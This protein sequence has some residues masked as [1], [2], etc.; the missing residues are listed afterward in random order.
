LSSKPQIKEK[1]REEGSGR[2]IN[3]VS[4][5]P[6]SLPYYPPLSPIPFPIFLVLDST[7]IFIKYYKNKIIIQ[8][9]HNDINTTITQ[10]S[11]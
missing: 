9:Q 3:V 10:Q 8:I 4:L 1:R 11:H 7:F 2:Y 6:F 5:I